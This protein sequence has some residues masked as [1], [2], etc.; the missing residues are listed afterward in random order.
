MF[1]FF[2]KKEDDALIPPRGKHFVFSELKRLKEIKRVNTTGRDLAYAWYAELKKDLKD[3]RVPKKGFN[4]KWYLIPWYGIYQTK[5]K[6]KLIKHD[7]L[8]PKVVLIVGNTTMVFAVHM[9]YEHGKAFI[10]LEGN[11]NEIANDYEANLRLV[12]NEVA[13]HIHSLDY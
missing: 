4:M 12:T 1:N 10:K 7:T 8:I 6:I 2:R 5:I 9:V 3:V 13:K 11:N